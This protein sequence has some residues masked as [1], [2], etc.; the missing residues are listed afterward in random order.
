MHAYGSAQIDSVGHKQRQIH[1]IK[2][3]GQ[4]S[5]GLSGSGKTQGRVRVNVIKRL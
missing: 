3:G 1:I 4:V 5:M 2:L